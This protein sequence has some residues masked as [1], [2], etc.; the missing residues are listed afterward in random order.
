MKTQAKIEDEKVN[1]AFSWMFK[2][3]AWEAEST[4]TESILMNTA[5]VYEV[6]EVIRKGY[7][8]IQFIMERVFCLKS[9]NFLI[10]QTNYF[11]IILSFFLFMVLI[12]FK[13]INKN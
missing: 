10:N 8:P 13:L 6:K 1:E 7:N 12:L 2:F 5:S 3:T 9:L 11:F 4:G